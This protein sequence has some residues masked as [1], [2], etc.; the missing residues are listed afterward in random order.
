MKPIR[1]TV[2]GLHSFREKQ[3]I[4]FDKLCEGGLFGI[5]GPTGSGKSSIL[6][7]MTL[8]L[9]GNVERAANNTNGIM[10]HAEQ[11]LV[12]SFTFE[13]AS[14]NGKRKYTVERS[15]KRSEGLRVKTAISRL[16]E[17]G[18][19]RVV[20]ADKTREVDDQIKQLLGLEMKDF[21]R[22][23]V[24]PQGK[25]AEF[26]SLKG[27]ERRQ[28]LQRLFNLEQ[29]G[30]QLNKKLKTRFINATAK[31]ETIC[32]EQAGLGNA[33]KET[34]DEQLQ[35]LEQLEQELKQQQ[36][37]LVQ[38]KERY[39]RDK[40]LWQ[41]QKEKEYIEQQLEKCR[42]EETEILTL[43][44]KRQKAEEA[45]RLLPY[46]QQY[47][48]AKREVE[49]WERE[50]KRIEQQL[51]VTRQQY[52]QAAEAYRFIRAKKNEQEPKLLQKKEQ[53]LQAKQLWE[54][55]QQMEREMKD[56]RARISETMAKEKQAQQAFEHLSQLYERA[57]D[58]QKS[59]KEQWRQKQ[60]PAQVKERIYRAYEE[61]KEVMV[62]D[63]AL[64]EIKREYRQ[65]QES[66]DRLVQRESVYE[67]QL[68]D[69]KKAWTA[70]F[71]RIERLYHRV[72]EKQI[73][74]EKLI[75]KIKQ[76]QKIAE[77]TRLQHVAASLAATL[78]EGSPC[79]VC[80]SL[81]HP[82]PALSSSEQPSE[83]EL[84]KWDEELERAQPLAS[85]FQSLK[86]QLEQ[87]AEAVMQEENREGVVLSDASRAKREAEEESYAPIDV[88]FHDLAAEVKALQQDYFQCRE[89]INTMLERRR[90]LEKQR[91]EIVNQRHSLQQEIEERLAKYQERER[92]KDERMQNW[93]AIYENLS[94]TAIEQM[95]DQ[96]RADE[97]EAQ[98]LQERIDKSVVFLEQKQEEC[99]QAKE[100]WQQLQRQ[101]AD[102]LLL[103][104]MKQQQ[105]KEYEQSLPFPID[106]QPLEHRLADVEQQLVQLQKQE[107][108]AY[109]SYN[110]MQRQYQLLEAKKQAAIQALSEG[111]KRLE[112]AE[113]KWREMLQQ[114]SF[115][116][117]DEIRKT[118]L[119]QEEKN[120][121]A[122]RIQQFRENWLKWQNEWQ[123]VTDRMNGMEISEEQWQQSASMLRQQEEK[124]T[125]LI[126]Q[127][128]SAKTRVEE[129]T[130][131]HKRFQELEQQRM[132]VER[133]VQQYRELQ[134]VLR[135]NSFVE[136]MAEEQ[137]IRVTRDA[138][139]R[140]GELTRQR[141]AIE[142]DSEGGF[143]IRD[144]ANGGVRRPVTTLSGGET[145]LTSLSLSLAL[146]AQIQL[147]GEYPL[148][149][150]FLDEGFGTLDGELLDV[151]IS[152]LERL[153]ANDMAIGVIS[154]VQEL[155]ARLP[156]RLI[157]E[158]AEP[159]GRGTRVKLEVM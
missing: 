19:E 143:M 74:L 100:Q 121:M 154:H 114:S 42:M 31:L 98:L 129:L 88:Q 56:I 86:I 65:K 28:M 127:V 141:Y 81:H 155:R 120:A 79:P 82:S 144:D 21:T 102:A 20:L 73:Q 151:V 25:F 47:E 39:E 109:E 36:L 122:E 18:S 103:Q 76:K 2:A 142:V 77:K 41:W 27:V 149:F 30:D 91:Q 9:Y 137:L 48:Q 131:K 29:Y 1:L 94:F 146:S 52:E 83:Q 87:L 97:K 16:I 34:L 130:E 35:Q 70:H 15:F 60:V 44:Q 59:L 64:Q 119:T 49:E 68:E 10:N 84:L 125:E 5:F 136:F 58:K 66:Y 51:H 115:A 23:V 96:L 57:L 72:C 158:P 124:T 80:G 6:D 8:A 24:L 105:Y 4:E 33:S 78:T 69:G 13:L 67:K 101:R 92:M 133:L 138:S 22:A 54:R 128:A 61:K 123:R 12:V 75:Y 117:A 53:L 145:F 156:K 106:E 55:M 152:A 147:R 43:E 95:M 135:G 110:G 32:A 26:L 90:T 113:D 14:A 63:Q 153:Q 46:A 157:V 116:N 118:P 132:A 108:E 45:E 17:E 40:E 148:Q 50:M 85:S 159:S 62:L 93:L 126:K 112:Q 99:E 3:V 150:F 104:Q 38:I 134:N 7:A 107:E 139:E 140:L 89:A 37:Y 111:E 71:Q 11:E